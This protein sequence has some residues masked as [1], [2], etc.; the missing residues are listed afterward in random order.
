MLRQLKQLNNKLTSAKQIRSSVITHWLRQN[1]LRQV[2]NMAGH[3]Y[4]RSTQR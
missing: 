1:N 3:K 4:V 2:Q